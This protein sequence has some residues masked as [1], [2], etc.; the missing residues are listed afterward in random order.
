MEN[1]KTQIIERLNQANNILVT[2]SSNPSVDQLSAAI[3]F[4]LVLNHMGK[5]ATAVF[6]G[7]VPSTIEFLKPEETLEKTTDSLRDF[8]IALDKSKADKLRY[9]VEDQMVK[10]FITPYRTT[11]TDKDLEYSQ[12]DYNVEVVVALGVREQ[13]D[14]DQAISTHGRILH[15]AT[16]IG[17]GTSESSLGSI[18]WMDNKA[19]S[20]CEMVTNISLTLKPDILEAQSATALLTGIVAET[21]RFS[22]EKTSS[23][24]M[25]YSAK[26]M[27]SGANQQLV[28]SQ[29]KDPEPKVEPATQNKP[30]EL[31]EPVET[32]QPTVPE[33]KPK[34]EPPKPEPPKAPVDG[35]LQIKHEDNTEQ[36]SSSMET[37]EDELNQ[38]HIDEEGT[39]KTYTELAQDNKKSAKVNE[40]NNSRLILD[41]PTLGGKLT[42]NTEPEHLDPSTDPLGVSKD[43][44]PILSHDNTTD[45]LPAVDRRLEESNSQPVMS[46]PQDD[47]PSDNTLSDLEAAVK[48]P[49]IEQNMNNARTAVEDAMSS[50][51]QSML[52]PIQ[53][54][55]A[56]PIDLNN[57]QQ[58]AT[59]PA[60]ETQAPS[61]GLRK[62]IPDDQGLPKDA[63]DSSQS[64]ASAPPPVPPPM[65]PPSFAQPPDN[66]NQPPAL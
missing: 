46:A 16:I 44:S 28:A 21:K 18:N 63:T 23:E 25:Q 32:T 2:V 15:D 49:H 42:A 9:K 20:L 48:S 51:S 17:L 31:P 45:N 27:S 54:L 60:I 50:S 43:Q 56:L 35:S 58:L 11:I 1:Q 3:G 53:S 24:T 52:D 37:N 65:M 29:L 33:D 39:L 10:I 4:A 47:K 36:K 38:I 13:S 66:L 41:K 19:S 55:N 62:L 14:L 12:G 61:D 22:N 7:Q 5:H 34:L 6:S 30:A 64:D 59:P 57:N 8:I 40:Q 26:L